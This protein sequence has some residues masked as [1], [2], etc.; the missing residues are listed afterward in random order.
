[1]RVIRVL[2]LLCLFIVLCQ[3]AGR[4]SVA[5]TAPAGACTVLSVTYEENATCITLNAIAGCDCVWDLVPRCAS[6][7]HCSVTACD[8]GFGLFI[9]Q[10]CF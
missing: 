6:Y 7:M 3:P 8:Y 4:A 10:S 9:E 5:R 2:T 1:M